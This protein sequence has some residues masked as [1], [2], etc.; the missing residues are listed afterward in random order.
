MPD[1]ESKPAK[2]TS[3]NPEVSQQATPEPGEEIKESHIGDPRQKAD[4]RAEVAKS[5]Q[6][7]EAVVIEKTLHKR[8]Q[9]SDTT[10]LVK[11]P[12][13]S[14]ATKHHHSV[15]ILD[16][17]LSEPG[18]EL[19]L[20]EPLLTTLHPEDVRELVNAYKE[21]K[22]ENLVDVLS[23]QFQR[24]EVEKLLVVANADIIQEAVSE[25]HE[26]VSENDIKSKE[27]VALLETLT[28]EESL[29]A[30]AAYQEKY[31]QDLLLLLDDRLN[32]KELQAINT[33]LRHPTTSAVHS[34]QEA[35]STEPPDIIALQS[36]LESFPPERL[37]KVLIQYEREH[38]YTLTEAF[39]RRYNGSQLFDSLIALNGQPTTLDEEVARIKARIAYEQKITPLFTQKLLRR[40]KG[41][42]DVLRE[43]QQDIENYY[44]KVR[45]EE[46]FLPTAALIPLHRAIDKA[47]ESIPSLRIIRST[48]ADHASGIIGIISGLFVFWIFV[49]SERSFIT[50]L[51]AGLVVFYFAQIT[52]R[53]IFED[54]QNTGEDIVESLR[55]KNKRMEKINNSRPA[56][57][58][59]GRRSR[60]IYARYRP[61]SS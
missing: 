19:H 48:L 23:K 58:R 28:P 42:H 50:S 37:P 56:R 30:L 11:E 5:E 52:S 17:F 7:V 13:V 33:A 49:R 47:D 44:E 10:N 40:Y 12:E 22:G 29:Q 54:R 1:F 8:T 32:V 26:I 24:Q 6:L 16:K 35:L 46:S 9:D 41:G 61:K 55:A 34:I 25:F 15:K 60:R 51:S 21:I 4:L 36:I 43:E 45:E 39:R 31:N 59:L 27:I 38:G 3:T 2:I 14:T 53:G 57:R 20:L 18:S